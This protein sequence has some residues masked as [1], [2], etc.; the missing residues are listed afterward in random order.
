M[1]CLILFALP[2]ISIF[3]TIF[4]KLLSGN[5][6][7]PL[8]QEIAKYLGASLVDAEIKRFA[9][10]EVFVEIKENV[11]G[12][13][14]FVIQS[15]SFPANDNIMELLI[16]IDALRR[17]SAKRITAVIPYFGYARQD[18]K[19][20]PRTPISAK[21]VS[22]LIVSAGANRVLTLDLHASQI[23]G[24]FDIPLDNLFAAPVF[25]RDIRDNFQGKDFMIVSPDVGGLV[26]ARVVASKLNVELAIVDKR[27][28]RAGV[29]EVMNIIGDVSGKDCIMVDDIVD[30]GGTLVNAADALLKNGA[31]SV[32]AYISHGVL[33]NHAAIKIANSSLTNL[34][35]T[36]SIAQNDEVLKAANVRIIPI[37]PLIGEAIRSVSEERS[38]STLFN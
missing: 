20:G 5:S 1:I 26:R 35:I 7:L 37:S 6:N 9:D 2:Q 21:L 16:M 36:D 17:A 22:N 18:R 13:D 11:R 4:M 29:S 33:S 8:A 34:I 31:R 32:S 19:V 15:T 38:V 28:Q 12:E 30:S 24:F 23:Q 14:V 27:R 3:Q 25:V 10:N